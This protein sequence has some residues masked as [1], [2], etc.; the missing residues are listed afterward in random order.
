[1]HNM[2]ALSTAMRLMNI[3]MNEEK[4]TRFIT[5]GEWINSARARRVG[6]VKRVNAVGIQKRLARRADERLD[7]FAIL[8]RDPCVLSVSWFQS[9]RSPPGTERGNTEK[10]VAGLVV[11]N[12]QPPARR[13]TNSLITGDYQREC[14]H[15]ASGNVSFQNSRT[16]GEL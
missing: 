12:R 8:V 14:T 3:Q 15:I 13:E 7:S 6:G 4:S 1:M 10:S 9:K 2:N 11:R 5:D 16:A